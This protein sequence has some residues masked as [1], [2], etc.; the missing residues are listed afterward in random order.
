MPPLLVNILIKLLE[1][2]LLTTVINKFFYRG[3][4][5]NAKYALGADVIVAELILGSSSAA[6][7]LWGLCSCCLNQTF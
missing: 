2:E 5:E 6:L 3:P 7:V 1:Q 4:S